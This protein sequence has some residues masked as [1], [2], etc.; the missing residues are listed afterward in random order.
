MHRERSPDVH[1]AGGRDLREQQ[2]LLLAQLRDGR[3]G[4]QAMRGARRMQRR[5]RAVLRGRG[6]LLG[7]VRRT[8]HGPRRLPAGGLARMRGRRRDMRW[9]PRLLL[10]FDVRGRATSVGSPPVPGDRRR[11]MPFGR[12]AL[13]DGER[14]LRRILP[15]GSLGGALLCIELRRGRKCVQFRRRLLRGGV[16][17]P[18]GLRFAHLRSYHTLKEVRR[19]SREPSLGLRGTCGP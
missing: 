8:G 19:P 11:R 17:L 6:L 1:T 10:R 4:R 12:N 13:R 5:V 15:A 18:G 2:R 9:R 3:R 7:G 16:G 14:V